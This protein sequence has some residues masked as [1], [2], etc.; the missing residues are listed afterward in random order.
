MI[1]SRVW[2]VPIQLMVDFDA[3]RKYVPVVT[4]MQYLRLHGLP[5]TLEVSNGHWDLKTY[6][7]NSATS[8]SLAVIPNYD[9]DGNLSIPRVD[10]L[11]ERQIKPPQVESPEWGVYQGLLGRI[12]MQATLNAEVAREFLKQ[13]TGEEWQDVPEM[14]EIA[15]KYGFSVVYTFDGQ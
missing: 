2:K 4:V 13:N 1:P 7:S 15:S 9:Y 11:P 10:R 14:V 8:P 3:L 6:H 5:E 12:G